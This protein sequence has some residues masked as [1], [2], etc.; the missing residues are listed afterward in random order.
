MDRFNCFEKRS[1][2]FKN[3]EEKR[4]TKNDK[5]QR[6]IHTIFCAT[7][8][9]PF[10][11]L[12]ASFCHRYFSFLH[13][14]ASYFLYAICCAQYT[15]HIDPDCMISCINSQDWA[16]VKQLILPHYNSYILMCSPA[17]YKALFLLQLLRSNWQNSHQFLC[18][19]L[20]PLDHCVM[21]RIQEGPSAAARRGQ[22]SF[23][24]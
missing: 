8:Y 11:F 17:N 23:L 16:I 10:S 7:T 13:L 15:I 22:R 19:S 24:H 12:L 4:K 2:S 3:E 14:K 18:E 21:Y 1:F 5:Q 6:T 20:Q 9:Q